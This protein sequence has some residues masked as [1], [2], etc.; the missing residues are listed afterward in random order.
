MRYFDV[1]DETKHW[2]AG[3]W[4]LGDFNER[5]KQATLFLGTGDYPAQGAWVKAGVEVEDG[6]HNIG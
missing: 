2:K 6:Q 1:A 3:V 4:I 5:F